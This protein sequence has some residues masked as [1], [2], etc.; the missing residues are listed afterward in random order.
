[1]NHRA[2][3]PSG[4]VLDQNY[5]I[6]RVI[7]SGG[8]GITYEAYDHGLGRPFAIKEYYPAEFGARDGETSVR[9][10]TET[11]GALFDKLKASFVREAQTL[12]R[13][14]HPAI[15]RVYRVFEA[16]GTA[17]MV[18]SL[19]DGVTLKGWL[20]DLGRSPT[21]DELDRLTGPLLSALETMHAANFVHRDIAPDNIILRDD[22]NPVLL[23]FGATR[24]VMAE[25]TSAFTGLVK[26]GYSSIEQYTV[27]TQAQGPWSDIYSIGATLYRC[28]AGYEPQEAT[29][30]MLRDERVP[31]QSLPEAGKY[32]PAFLAGIDLALAVRPEDRPQSIAELRRLLF[33]G[34]TAVDDVDARADPPGTRPT[35]RPPLATESPP[36]TAGPPIDSGASLP[37]PGGD[38]PRRSGRSTGSRLAAASALIAAVV[39]TI[40]LARAYLPE[41]PAPAA[42]VARNTAP[43]STVESKSTVPVTPVASTKVQAPVA[44]TAEQRLAQWRQTVEPMSLQVQSIFGANDHWW[45]GFVDRLKRVSDGKLTV[46]YRPPGA[47][48]PVTNQLDAVSDGRIVAGWGIPSLWIN[49][50]TV[51]HIYS[52]SVP[53]GLARADFVRWLQARGERELEALY[54]GDLGL[55]VEPITCAVGWPEGLWTKEPVADLAAFRKLIVRSVG[56]PAIVMQGMGATA[57]FITFNLIT[58]ALDTGLISAAEMGDPANDDAFRVWRYAKN[59]YYPSFHAPATNLV[60]DINLGRWRGMSEAQRGLIIEACRQNIDDVKDYEFRIERAIESIKR[61]NVTVREFPDDVITAA[62]EARDAAVRTMSS[63]N[64]AFAR[65]WESYIS[66]K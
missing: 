27:D 46:E 24:R 31:A 40:M 59:F 33:A 15:V 14:E 64:P 49:K 25:L 60:L 22:G 10:R 55:K 12:S 54:Q 34:R 52:G 1:M 51:L 19:E 8:F 11:D 6:R 36:K 58:N 39:A 57:R 29:M 4:L 63:N 56:L 37:I 35:V 17:Y 38:T 47:V 32:R 23:D 41:R 13:F 28:V 48:V 62:R 53:L 44:P 65:A 20:A 26:R 43:Q 45:R 2:T 61:Q 16:H 30:R 50:S 7:G 5:E 21:Q 42:T 18:M 9:P 66:F 3:L